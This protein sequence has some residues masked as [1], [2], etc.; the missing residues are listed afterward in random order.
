VSAR[1]LLLSL[2]AAGLPCV[3][4]IATAQSS[5]SSSK[6]DSSH[7]VSAGIPNFGL[8]ALGQTE[9]M[10]AVRWDCIGVCARPDEA[11]VFGAEA[12]GTRFIGAIG[13]PHE[14]APVATGATA[15]DAEGTAGDADG[16]ALT[17]RGEEDA[18]EGATG[19][20]QG[21]VFE[22][23]I[24]NGGRSKYAPA[25]LATAAVGAGALWMANRGGDEHTPV[26]TGAPLRVV[27]PR[28]TLSMTGPAAQPASQTAT[29][30]EPAT[31]A[32]LTTGLAAL[33]LARRRRQ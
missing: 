9:R 10:E 25:L 14:F 16:F 12:A 6:R 3:A 13:A 22:Q 11:A 24:A 27:G 4:S 31:L 28:P 1:L 29:V 15:P 5:F 18:G 19:E 17:Y 32:L 21:G 8:F 2:S 20:E 26:H 23:A 7:T 30:P 33:G